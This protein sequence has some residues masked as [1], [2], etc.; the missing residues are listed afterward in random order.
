MS[1]AGTCDRCTSVA[2]T[3]ASWGR[4]LL[5]VGRSPTH[6][7]RGLLLC[8]SP[9]RAA[10]ARTQ[11]PYLLPK[12]GQWC[13]PKGSAAGWGGMAWLRAGP[14]LPGLPCASGPCSPRSHRSP[15]ST[16]CPET[17]HCGPQG[18]L[19]VPGPPQVIPSHSFLWCMHRWVSTWGQPPGMRRGSRHREPPSS[20]R[21]R[22]FALN[23][24]GGSSVGG[25]RLSRVSGQRCLAKQRL[26]HGRMCVTRPP[27]IIQNGRSRPRMEWT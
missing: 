1:L 6:R 12:L 11:H 18:G 24:R 25:F 8:L 2:T 21:A 26:S 20:P 22:L 7:G 23:R 27:P 3:L 17:H 4:A 5:G 16:R 14:R 10:P 19:R 13:W 9:S 15:E